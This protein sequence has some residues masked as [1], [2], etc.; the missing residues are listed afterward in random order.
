M[1]LHRKKKKK[2][3]GMKN[4]AALWLFSITTSRAVL[5]DTIFRRVEC[6]TPAFK[7]CFRSVYQNTGQTFKS[8]LQEVSHSYSFKKKSQEMMS[9]MLNIREIQIKTTTRHHLTPVRMPI[10]KRSAKNQGWS[11]CGEMR[12]LLHLCWNDNSKQPLWRQCVCVLNHFSRVRLFRP[13]GL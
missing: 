9:I 6:R 7:E 4:A 10:A 1:K 3:M 5:M 11:W 13:R 2:E 12:T 8:L